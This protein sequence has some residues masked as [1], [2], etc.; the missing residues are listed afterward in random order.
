MSNWKQWSGGDLP[1]P[2]STEVE[3]KYRSGSKEKNVAGACRWEHAD[4]VDGS[5]LS[6]SVDI[7][8]FRVLS[9]N[10]EALAYS[11]VPMVDSSDDGWVE[12][13]GGECPLDDE[14]YMRVKLRNGKT[15]EP[16]IALSWVWEHLGDNP[17][18]I[19]A[20][21]I[22]NDGV[23]PD[24]VVPEHTGSH[25]SYYDVTIS[26]WTNP[27]HQQDKPVTICCNDIIEALEMNYA[28]ANVFKAQWR[29][30][31]AKQGKLKKGNTTV[32]DAEKS[33]FFSDRVL[34]QE[35]IDK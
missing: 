10:S 13:G 17:T 24:I 33:V 16:A 14:C 1:V 28:Q 8:E 23:D 20:Y 2:Y 35:S 11:S 19:V 18:D 29:I 7:V 12:W 9:D 6:P 21:K 31:A 34:I 25:S 15:S 4:N 30:A 27:E 5:D 32:Y 26:R 3:V 22:E